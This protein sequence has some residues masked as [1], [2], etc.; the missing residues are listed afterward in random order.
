M[1]TLVTIELE[2]EEDEVGDADVYN[3]LSELMDSNC[4]DWNTNKTLITN[5]MRKLE[6]MKSQRRN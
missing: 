1:T 3:Y 4:L 2:F 6:V 5:P